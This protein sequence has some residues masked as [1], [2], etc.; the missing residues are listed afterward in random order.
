MTLVLKI[1][2]FAELVTRVSE[3]AKYLVVINGENETISDLQLL[4]ESRGRKDVIFDQVDAVS[5]NFFSLFTI[6]VL[7][8]TSQISLQWKGEAMESDRNRSSLYRIERSTYTITN[9]LAED[10][11][12]TPS[13]RTSHRILNWI[14]S[15]RFGNELKFDYKRSIFIA[16]EPGEYML[17]VNART[18]A[19]NNFKR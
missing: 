19:K 15:H 13:N 5:S 4:V 9:R 12:I 1:Y 16:K 7:N 14:R 17:I 2:S 6:V 3:P 11:L 10:F 8:T 18:I